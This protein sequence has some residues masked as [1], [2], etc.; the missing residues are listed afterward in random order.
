MR[1]LAAEPLSVPEV[2][3]ERGNLVREAV[4]VFAQQAR[5]SNLPAIEAMV[6]L[7]TLLHEQ[8]GGPGVDPGTMEDATDIRRVRR[9]F[10]EAF[11]FERR[12]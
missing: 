11:Y 10:V 8:Y 7:K 5:A 1:A 12:V 2:E 3:Q 6:R 4:R 9:W